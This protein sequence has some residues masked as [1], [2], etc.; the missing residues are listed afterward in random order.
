MPRRGLNKE[1]Q[2]HLRASLSLSVFG[3][4]SLSHLS[5]AQSCSP[6]SELPPP[7]CWAPRGFGPSGTLPSKAQKSPAPSCLLQPTVLTGCASHR[8]PTWFLS[9][10][11][12]AVLDTGGQGARTCLSA[13][14]R[15]LGLAS[16]AGAEPGRM[17]PPGQ[18]GTS[19][20]LPVSRQWPETQVCVRG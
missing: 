10:P 19:S 14:P 3:S 6:L 9:L 4:I 12:L 8:T 18:V 17:A 1:G 20:S 13:P 15:W 16:A 5:G 7:A 2:T 11:G